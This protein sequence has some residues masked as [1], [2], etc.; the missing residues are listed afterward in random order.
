MC[1]RAAFYNR[2]GNMIEFDPYSLEFSNDPYPIYKRL[3]DEAP[4]HHC[5]SLNFW[6]LS[7]YADVLE[8][9]RDFQTYS[10]AGG[11]TIEGFDA[12]VPLLIVKDPPE[13]RWHK[14]LVTKVFTSAR[15][16]A[17]EP[18]I[19][20]LVGS[21]LDKAA[22]QD[23]VDLVE[24]FALQVPLHVISELIGIP[25]DLREEI[26]RLTN[27]LLFR[28]DTSG[29]EELGATMAATIEI[30]QGLVRERRAHPR[31]DPISYLIESEV[32][33]DTGV[34]RR[35]TDEEM[36]FRFGELAAAGHETVAK[37]IPNGAIA[38]QRFPSERQKLVDNPGL[39]TNAVEEVLRFD[40]PSQLQGR[41]TTRDVTLHGITIP[42][43]SK[44]ML[45]TGAATRDERKFENPDVFD[46]SREASIES[47]FFGFG[48]HRC[49]GI[50]L[51]RLELRIVFEE[52][53]RRFPHFEVDPERA[54]RSVLSN[55]RGVKTLPARLRH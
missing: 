10:S 23:E 43:G 29:L 32:Q 36:A 24:A 49:L 40:P 39:V 9:H 7:R 44:T 51:A 52:L 18:F 15:M 41:T 45:L 34:V 21:L 4:V 38:F 30:Y 1:R 20:N 12:F 8:A 22:Q 31:N 17:L 25:Q 53:F 13:H 14:A 3:R 28:G 47:V 48:P 11:V 5:A 54:T 37:A 42:A 27:R 33:D 26:H 2:N 19:R 50:H 46:I 6:A 16:A 55:V 35:L